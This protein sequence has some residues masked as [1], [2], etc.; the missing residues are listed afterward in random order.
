[1]LYSKTTGG[2]YDFVIHGNGIPEDA[3]E[4]TPAEHAALLES[5]SNGMAIIADSEGKPQAVKPTAPVMTWDIVRIKRDELLAASD[6]TQLGDSPLTDAKC[7]EWATYRQALRDLTEAS[8]PSAVI[9]PT[10]PTK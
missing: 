10:A 7:S 3:V 6:W 9:W 8:S 5:Q 1:M 2:F 4:I